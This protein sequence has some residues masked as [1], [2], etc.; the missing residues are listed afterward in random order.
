MI[1]IVKLISITIGVVLFFACS[2]GNIGKV[3]QVF[4]QLS[5]AQSVV[6]IARDLFYSPAPSQ[7]ATA[8]VV[9]AVAQT[10]G[11]VN[12]LTPASAYYENLNPGVMYWIELAR[13]GYNLARVSNDWLFK[14]GDNIRIHVTVN[15]DGYLQVW[16]RGSTGSVSAIPVSNANNEV[17]IGTDYV[18]PPNGG[19]LTFDNNPGQERLNLTFASIKSSNEILNK[20]RMGSSEIIALTGQYMNSP[21]RLSYIEGGSKDLIVTGGQGSMQNQTPQYVGQASPQSF[22]LNGASNFRVDESVYNAPG[23]YIVNNAR[24]AVKEPVVVEIV[25][26]HQP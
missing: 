21:N 22:N 4:D 11:T 23:N 9:S 17:R 26:N 25:L 15:S 5:T 12:Q 10:A 19:W 16:H 6:K 2:T 7:P 8:P 24:G 3:G 13:P 18:I 14:S 20:M 1:R